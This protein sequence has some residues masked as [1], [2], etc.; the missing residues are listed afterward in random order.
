MKAEPAHYG[1]VRID[2][3]MNCNLHC[4]YCH[5]GR[6][7]EV[8]ELDLDE[9]GFGARG[10]ERRKR[11]YRLRHGADTDLRLAGR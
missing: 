4:I 7:R 6:T 3:I 11:L 5:N 8:F 10:I 1:W 2:P 9:A